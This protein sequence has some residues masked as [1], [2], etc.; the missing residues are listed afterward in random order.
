MTHESTVDKQ[1]GT[2]CS[3]YQALL[4][5]VGAK[6]KSLGLNKVEAGGSARGPCEPYP[7]IFDSCAPLSN[8]NAVLLRPGQLQIDGLVPVQRGTDSELGPWKRPRATSLD[9]EM[10]GS[11]PLEWEI[12]SMSFDSTKCAVNIVANDVGP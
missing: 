11:Q 2:T 6:R 4:G 3:L 10:V 8:I 7:A 5:P 9:L 12:R 1:F